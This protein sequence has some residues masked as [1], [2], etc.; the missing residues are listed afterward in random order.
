MTTPVSQEMRLREE[1]ARVLVLLEKATP[2]KWRNDLNGDAHMGRLYG[3]E[4]CNGCRPVICH[5]SNV[6]EGGLHCYI[7]IDPLQGMQNAEA[8]A[9]AINFLRKHGAHIAETFKE[10]PNG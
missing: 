1:L 5:T 2:G 9:A 8:I 4:M 6:C 10:T 3:G 7:G